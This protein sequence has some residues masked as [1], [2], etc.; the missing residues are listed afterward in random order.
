MITFTLIVAP[1]NII[2]EAG[3]A[4]GA[5]LIARGGGMEFYAIGLVAPV[6]DRVCNVI[7]NKEIEVLGS[8]GKVRM[9]GTNRNE[10]TVPERQLKLL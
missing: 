8:S 1:F 7:V 10:K 3:R 2:C 4:K 5:R 9:L 6:M